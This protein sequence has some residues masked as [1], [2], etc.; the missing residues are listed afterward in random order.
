MPIWSISEEARG[1]V[2]CEKLPAATAA[3]QTFPSHCYQG[4][5]AT[6]QINGR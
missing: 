3:L 4:M 6:P 5:V 2:Q 1:K